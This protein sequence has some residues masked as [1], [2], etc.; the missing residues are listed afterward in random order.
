MQR[1]TGCGRSFTQNLVMCASPFALLAAVGLG[2]TPALAQN[3]TPPAPAAAGAPADRVVVTARFREESVQSTPLA[4]TTMD[5]E[6]LEA[7][8]IE[9]V[10]DIGQFVPNAFFRENVGNFGPTSTIG[11]RGVSQQDFSYAFEPAVGVYIDDIYHGTLT[12]SDMDLLDLERVE[13]LRGP[14]GTLFGKNSLGGAIRLITRK[15]EG[16]GTGQIQASY[17]EYDLIELKAAYDFSL[18]PD[19]VFARITGMSKQRDGYGAALDF[20][21]EMIRR[22]TPQ[23]AGIGDGVSGAVVGVD[24]DGPGPLRPPV[25]PILTTPGSAADDAFS[26]PATVTPLQG[27]GCELHSLGGIQSD[28]LRAAVRILATPDFELNLVADYSHS[29]DEPLPQTLLTPHSGATD[30]NYDRE[31]IYARYGVRY[32]LDD[33][34]VTG[35]PYTNFSNYADPL[36]GQVYDPVAKTDAWG[37]SG[38]GDWDIADSVAAT[39]VAA[40]RTYEMLWNSDTDLTPFPVQGSDYLQEHEQLQLETRV[41]GTLLQD[42]LEWTVGAFYYDSES[43]AYNTTEF[44]AFDYSGLLRNFVADDYYTTEN[45]SGFAH[46][47]Y[48]LTDRLSISGGLRYTEENKTNIFDHQPGLI[49]RTEADFSDDRWDWKLSADF[50]ATDWV[51][52]YAQAATGFRSAGFT[53]RIFTAGQLQGIPPEEVLTYEAG[54]KFSLFDDRL[55]LNTAVFM[56]DYDPRL[57]QV[58]GVSQCDAPDNLNPTPYFLQGGNC[59]AGTALAGSTGL[60]WFY[61]SN[62]PGELTGF[63][64]ELNAEPIERLNVNASLGYVEY[65]NDETDVTATDYRDPSA[66]LVPE[67]TISAGIQYAFELFG[68]T[69]HR[70]TPRL[71]WTYQSHRTNGAVN[72]PNTCPDECVPAYDLFNARLTYDNYE[73]DWSLAASVTNLLD[74]FYW[75]QLGA[76]FTTTGAAPSARTGVPGAPRMWKLTATKRF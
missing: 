63:E 39:F 55:Y 68:S 51:F 59:P 36:Q 29:E 21:C 13:V 75:Q 56:S 28:S 70:L 37:V 18:V 8:S 17:G 32:T 31:V 26:L 24:P 12:G 3:Q 64:A 48:D 71:D 30:T 19:R 61:Y 42:Q 43:R 57:I 2:A 20:T 1:H 34:F 72:Q 44:G 45:K 22:G 25:T 6:Q 16:D 66:L 7:K 47:I 58:G 40:Y 74:D 76:A 33:R 67:W 46:L 5:A 54:A 53:P 49:A 9:N 14:Q 69:E 60:P 23:R 41:S 27:D 73:G 38:T 65:E 11:L 15:P 50:Q 52:L 4:I 35:D 62:S 10:E